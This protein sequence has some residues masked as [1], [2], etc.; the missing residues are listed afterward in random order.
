MLRNAVWRRVELIAYDKV[1]KLA[2]LDRLDAARY[3]PARESEMKHRDWDQA[4]EAYFEEHNDIRLDGDARGAS[5][6]DVRDEVEDGV[7][8]RM[9]RQTLADPEGHHDWVIDAIVDL[10]ASDQLGEPILTVMKFHRLG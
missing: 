9:I 8:L 10:D 3:E 2:E 7:R 1:A 5:F 4:L 6:F